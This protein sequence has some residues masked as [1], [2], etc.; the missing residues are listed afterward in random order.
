MGSSSDYLREA[1]H[2]VEQLR[3]TSHFWCAQFI[4]DRCRKM[5]ENDEFYSAERLVEEVRYELG[6]IP[7]F[8]QVIEQVSTI[9]EQMKG[10]W[11]KS[12]WVRSSDL[13][14]RLIQQ[15]VVS[16]STAFG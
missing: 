15:G 7:I 9:L 10:A 3:S 13:L 4:F 5:L 12:P 1:G 11:E 14:E 16:S 6:E 2:D 8:S